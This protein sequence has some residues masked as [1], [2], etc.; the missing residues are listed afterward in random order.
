[1]KALLRTVL[2]AICALAE[3]ALTV[4]H[5]LRMTLREIQDEIAYDLYLERR[6]A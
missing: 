6:S 4:A 2:R 3:V 1:V 5:V